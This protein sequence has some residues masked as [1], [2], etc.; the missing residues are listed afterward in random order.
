MNNVL[1]PDDDTK[2]V[3]FLLKENLA[4]YKLNNKGKKLKTLI[5]DENQYRYNP[6]KPISNKLKSKLEKKRQTNEYR[7]YQ[8]KEL[9]ATD[10]VRKL[11]IRKRATITEE[12]SAFK[13][14]ANAYTISNIHLK[15]LNGLTYFPYQFERLNEYLEKHK[16]MKL[17]ATVKISVVN[18]YEEMQDVIV[19][20]RSYTIIDS[21]ELQEALKNMRSDIGARILDMALYQSGLMV[22]KV[23]EIHMMY[24]KYNPTRAGKNINLPKWISLKKACINIKNIDEKCFKY[25]IQCGYHKIFEKSDPENFYHYKKIEDGLGFDGINFPANNNDIDK[26]EELN[27]DVSVNVF[28]VDEEQEQ[29]V[30]GRKLKNK[31]AKCHIDLLRIDE[32]DISHYVYVKDCSRLLNSQKSKFRNKSYFCKYCHTGFGTQELLNKHYEKGCMEVEGQQIEMP[33]PDEKLKFKHHFKKLRCPFVIYADFEGL[34]EELKQPEDDEIKTYKYQ[35]HKPCGFM[36]NL[37]NAVDNTNQEFLYRGDDAV[38]VFCKKINEIRDEIKEKMQEKKEI[39]MTDEDKKDFETATHCFICGDKFKNSCKNEKEAEKYKKVRD[40]CHFTGK[41]RGCAHSIC[42]LNF[43][44]RYFKIPVF[45]HNMK[46]YDGHLIIQN[47]EKLSD[48]KKIDVIAQNSEKFINIG[49]DSLSVK[50]SFSFITASLD[51]LVSMTKYDNTD[52][53]ERSK[54]VLRDN[55]QSNFRYSSKNDIIKTEKCLDLLTEKGVYPYDYMNAFDKFNDE[56]LPSKEQF[57]SRLTE[58]GITNDDYTKAKQIWKHFDIKN[59]GEYHDLYLKTDVLLLTDVFENF[60]DMCLSYYGLDPVYY[61]TLPNFAF[62]AMLKLTGIEIDLVYNQEMFEMIEAGLR[63]GM[64]QTTCKKAEANNK[65]MG[66]DYDKNKASSYINYLDANNL[67]GLSMIQKLPYR[68]LKWED[69]ITEDDIINNENGRTGFILEVDLEYP[70]ELHDLH[71]DY[72]LAPE[73][74]NVKSNMLSEKQVEIYKLIN[75]SKEP[76]DEK[77]KKLILNLNDKSKYVV[78]IR[79]LQFY[80]KH[81]LKLKK[82]HRAIKF[83]QKEILKP[84]IEFN[85]EK[86]KNARNDFEKDIFKLLNNAV[87]GKTME[88]K[89]KHLDFEIVSDERRFMKCVNNPSFKHSH[90]INENLVGVEK[91]K[92]KLKLDKPIFI[93]MSILDLSKQHMY[94]FYYDVMKPKYGDNIRMVYTDTD[95][96]VFHTKTDDIYQDLKEINDEMDFSGYDKNHK[97]Y[98]ATNKKVLGKFKDECEGKITTGF[99]GLRPK[100]YAFKIHGDDK[101]YK[102]CKGTAKNT[103]KRKIRY[104]D[105]KKVLETNEVIYRSFNSIRSKNHKI[106]SINTTKVSL[107]S[108]ENKRYW[109]TSVDSL[110]FG[111]FKTNELKNE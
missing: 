74:M 49:F 40:H 20:T 15:G 92:P 107:N 3:K 30:I 43:C 22:V 36:L 110:A 50:D 16:G 32:D 44:N 42:N 106:F 10:T 90:I 62:D 46:N 81:G 97:C 26:F 23:K 7:A 94:K 11:A 14:Y 85:T 109:T 29:I 95:S 84:Y 67:Y 65:Y 73:V 53:K 105:Y 33:T 101:E 72:P 89:R 91:Q 24:N 17:N 54:W 51:K 68:S 78:H 47:A 5:I 104:D 100:C 80:L 58:E 96:F 55:W 57:Y 82:I 25:A 35:E 71:N 83:E 12:Q 76:K 63:G 21:D 38:D 9:A 77:T 41:Y 88:D 60:R 1:P 2:T 102:K 48:K 99:I 75:G 59:M 69:K 79:T 108:Y 52:E 19:R 87:F 45:F 13:A 86:R 34:T 18:I 70:K 64:T 98:D 66:S 61:Y 56:Q 39:E 111:H 93:G 31:D 8:I 4:T 6:T 27:H 37:V 103:V 28:E